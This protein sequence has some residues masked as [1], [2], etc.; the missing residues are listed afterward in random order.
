MSETA[1][2][3]DQLPVVKVVNPRYQPS[4]AELDEQI[5][6]PEGTT[7][8]QLARALTRSVKVNYTRKPKR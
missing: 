7:P 8:E 6:F 5:E 4:K 1:E 2:K 3:P